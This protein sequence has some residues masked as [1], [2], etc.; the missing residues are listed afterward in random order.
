MVCSLLCSFNSSNIDRA[1]QANKNL[2][3]SFSMH[4]QSKIKIC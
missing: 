2:A 4:A 1:G 3:A